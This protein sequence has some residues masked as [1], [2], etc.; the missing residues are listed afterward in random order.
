MSVVSIRD[1]GRNPSAVVNEVASTGRP[2]L[3]TKN[4]RPVA[5]LVRID[6]VGMEDW[7]LATSADPAIGTHLE[8]DPDTL[9]AAASNR[10]RPENLVI[11]DLTDG[12]SERF[13]AVL[14]RV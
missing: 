3:V 1:L 9:I 7:V 6:Q 2:A 10:P 14:E 4:G 13:W 8:L 12:E 5:A 11:G